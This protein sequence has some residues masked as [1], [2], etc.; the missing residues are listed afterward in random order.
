M[1]SISQ[2][3][4]RQEY[5]SQRNLTKGL[6]LV[7][8]KRFVLGRINSSKTDFGG[9][10]GGLFESEG[11]R[12]NIALVDQRQVNIQLLKAHAYGDTTDLFAIERRKALPI[13]IPQY[14]TLGEITS[15]D[16]INLREFNTEELDDVTKLVAR[17]AKDI[18]DASIEPTLEWARICALGGKLLNP[19]GTAY[20][21]WETVFGETTNKID[22]N[23][24][25]MDEVSFGE[26][27]DQIQA[28]VNGIAYTNIVALCGANAF[29]YLLTNPNIREAFKFWGNRDFLIGKEWFK[30]ISECP[31]F[32]YQ[33]FDFV[34]YPT[35][36]FGSY[37]AVLPPDADP[38][39]IAGSPRVF[40]TDKI[41]FIPMGIQYMFKDI[42][43]SG[44]FIETAHEKGQ[45]YFFKQKEDKMGRSV[46]LYAQANR[47]FYCAKPSWITE[48]TFTP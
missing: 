19:D 10:E 35:Y 43:G 33:N 11:I 21:D 8:F 4:G 17:T 37:P 36:Q 1:P 9:Y 42:M 18:V 27:A 45:P 15:K 25:T 23:V 3:L 6:N 12:G 48:L 34:K 20:I 14:D 24:V 31:A 16:T 46:K 28:N 44:D 13:T 22:A 40:P 30:G 47:L 2:F 38:D 41:Y 32:S 39:V 29:N 7:P 5:F 26:I